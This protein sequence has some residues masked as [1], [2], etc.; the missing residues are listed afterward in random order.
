MKNLDLNN[1]WAKHNE[2]LPE[3]VIANHNKK[4][5][6]YR[7]ADAVAEGSSPNDFDVCNYAEYRLRAHV[8]RQKVGGYKAAIDE[9]IEKRNTIQEA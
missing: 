5:M 8:L 4:L 9:E 3:L 2:L 7:I 6:A 1:L